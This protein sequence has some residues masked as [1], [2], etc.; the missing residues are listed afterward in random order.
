MKGQMAIGWLARVCGALFMIA[1]PG[2]TGAQ[3]AGPAVAPVPVEALI[4]EAELI[5]VVNVLTVRD[6]PGTSLETAKLQLHE[7]LKAPPGFAAAS[8][9]VRFPSTSVPSGTSRLVVSSGPTYLPGEKA[10]V[11]LKA[12]S[13][14]SYF[15]TVRALVGKR[16][17]SQGRVA[18]DGIRLD[19]F[20]AKIRA[21]VSA[22]VIPGASGTAP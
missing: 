21:G 18:F 11:F 15:E 19:A 6:V 1:W 13:D 22:P 8:I 12:S 2:G 14:G 4:Q 9:D 10:V 20:L 7:V 3:V 16:T 5:A 17:I